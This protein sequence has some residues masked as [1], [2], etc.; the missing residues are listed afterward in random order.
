[1]VVIEPNRGS[2]LW[3]AV[4]GA[5]EPR[6]RYHRCANLTTAAGC[7][8]LVQADRTYYG[9]PFCLSCRLNRTIPNL[10]VVA[11]AE[12]WH[13][14]ETAKRRLVSSLLALSL[15]VASKVLEDPQNGL[16]FDLLSPLP[17]GTRVITG[18]SNGVVTLNIEEADDQVRERI[19]NDLDE[20]YR[21]LL[22]HLRHETGHYYWDRLIRDDA[23]WLSAF[24]NLFGD[25]RQ[26]YS[27]ALQFHYQQGPPP[28]WQSR[29]VSA[30]ASSHPWED[31]AESWAHYLHMV[32][33]LGSAQSF[34]L[35]ASKVDLEFEPFTSDVL[36]DSGDPEAE[37]FLGLVNSWA[38]L[39]AALNELSRSMGL[40][41][42][43]P[44]VLSKE[45]VR[46]LH[47]I[48]TVITHNAAYVATLRL[49][50]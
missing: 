27:D 12:R 29:F 33:T 47:F 49:A 22:G 1:M 17:G 45:A 37:H 43:Y 24:R 20:P 50:S 3:K 4:H 8:W 21:T 42:F 7:N 18:H 23:R 2:G 39:A 26:N 38:M 28:D 15:P 13:R 44:F 6:A 34:G 48:H 25:D 19:R 30:Y 9:Q 35:D 5:T 36:H 32:D 46:K 40:A 14:V 16:A 31:W 11:N 10:S 41:D